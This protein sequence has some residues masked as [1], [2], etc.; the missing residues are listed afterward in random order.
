MQSYWSCSATNFVIAPRQL[1]R[2]R[3]PVGCTPENTRSLK[4]IT[5]VSA[6]VR[7]TSHGGACLARPG[8]AR[9]SSC[10]KARRTIR[11]AGPANRK[12][13]LHEQGRTDHPAG[14][15]RDRHPDRRLLSLVEPR[16]AAPLAAALSP[17]EGAVAVDIVP[18]ASAPHPKKDLS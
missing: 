7:A 11:I 4:A 18:R 3:L 10:Y 12:R 5:V 6:N 17:L 16:S 8:F 13:A 14:E 9:N 2:C 1:P 15:D